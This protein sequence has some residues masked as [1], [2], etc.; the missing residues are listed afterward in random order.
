MGCNPDIF[1]GTNYFLKLENSDKEL[2]R[3]KL[4]AKL[5]KDYFD[6]LNVILIRGVVKKDELSEFEKRFN[7]NYNEVIIE[8]EFEYEMFYEQLNTI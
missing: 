4:F 3:E 2:I 1:S 5:E 6:K 7:P 8:N